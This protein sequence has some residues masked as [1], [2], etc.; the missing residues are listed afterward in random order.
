MFVEKKQKGMN[1]KQ[2]EMNEKHTDNEP[3]LE[4]QHTLQPKKLYAKY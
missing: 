4:H 1:E 2:K 3:K